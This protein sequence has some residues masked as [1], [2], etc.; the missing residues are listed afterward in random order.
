MF[1]ITPGD[2]EAFPSQYLHP[3]QLIG[4][5][6]RWLVTLHGDKASKQTNSH[7]YYV[8]MVQRILKVIVKVNPGI[9]RK[10]KQ[11]QQSLN[12]C[13]EGLASHGLVDT[14][15]TK[16]KNLHEALK[17]EIHRMIHQLRAAVQKLDDLS[18]THR[19]MVLSSRASTPAPSGASHQRLLQLT[20]FDIQERLIKNKSLFNVVE[21]AVSSKVGNIFEFEKRF[22]NGNYFQIEKYNNGKYFQI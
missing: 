19:T 11:K 17:S 4:K 6:V 14:S 21:P 20:Q 9:K 8:P 2:P 7:D 3:E 15:D 13:V 18:L 22:Q 5:V 10:L 1:T 12:T 16:L